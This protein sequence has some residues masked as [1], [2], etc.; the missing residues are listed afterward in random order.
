MIYP[1]SSTV[2]VNSRRAM[3]L[4]VLAGRAG[5]GRLPDCG[6]AIPAAE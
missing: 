6:L 4:T 3:P 1:I 5:G 2:D